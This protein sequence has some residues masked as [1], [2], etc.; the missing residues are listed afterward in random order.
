MGASFAPKGPSP[1]WGWGLG[2]RSLLRTS[3]RLLPAV[4]HPC[5]SKPSFACGSQ[6]SDVL[7]PSGNLKL[8]QSEQELQ[9]TRD[10]RDPEPLPHCAP[11]GV[12]GETRFSGPSCGRCRRNLLRH[13][14]W[15][16][17]ETRAKE[18]TP[19][20]R[21]DQESRARRPPSLE[22]QPQAHTTSHVPPAPSSG[23]TNPLG[24]M[25][26]AGP[27]WQAPRL[28]QGQSWAQDH[29]QDRL[30]RGPA[31]AARPADAGLWGTAAPVP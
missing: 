5:P 4:P 16:L 21:Q 19:Q 26:H 12:Q 18:L 27:E 22:A 30:G 31:A 23:S 15:L 2:R 1:G 29:P 24:S 14:S 20:K 7:P 17:R 10:P 13:V 28:A 9:G 3:S 11:H 25:Q 8:M 6:S